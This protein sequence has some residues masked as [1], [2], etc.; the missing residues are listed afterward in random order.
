VF[1]DTDRHESFILIRGASE[2]SEN[3]Q[4]DGR[5]IIN[6]NVGFD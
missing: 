3:K 6:D 1:A 5:E 2:G 4:Q